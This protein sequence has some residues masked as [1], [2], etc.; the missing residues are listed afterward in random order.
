M[1]DSQDTLI[2]GMAADGT[3]RCVAAVTTNTIAEAAS[4]H[5]TASTATAAFGR[6]L[7]GT[8][9]LAATYKDFDRLTVQIRCNGIIEGIV[10]EANNKGGVRGYVRNPA[11]DVPFNA[12]G[13]YDV[14]AIVGEGTFYVTR[15]A[16]FDIGLY[17]EPYQGSVPLVSGEI[18]EDFAYY[19]TKS[20]QIPSGVML[21]V[22]VNPARS[23]VWAAGGVLLQMM[24]GAT[25]ETIAEIERAV[26]NSPGT[27]KLIY[28]GA[29]P[30]DLL[31][32]ALGTIEFEVLDEKPVGF[33]CT[34]SMERAVS[35][36]SSLD[37]AELETILRE[38]A[39]ATLVCHFCNNKYTL[40]ATHL[41]EILTVN[42]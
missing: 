25:E 38:D 42:S 29:S 30:T 22:I 10:G 16:G 27:A 34:C 6:L 23:E 20:E 17:R 8:L 24:P 41:E 7:T 26:Q 32:A 15:E 40:D 9:L 4:R 14:R 19:L 35:I 31:K 13:K 12:E 33:Y 3:V 36:I 28:E 1:N 37:R 39:G 18:G 11:A 21:G 5:E 2:H